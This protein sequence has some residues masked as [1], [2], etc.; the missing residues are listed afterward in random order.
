[1]LNLI[2]INVQYLP[3]AVFSFEKGSNGQKCSSSSPNH[4]IPLL[5]SP[6]FPISP[7]F[8]SPLLFGKPSILSEPLLRI[9]IKM[10][11]VLHK[12]FF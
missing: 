1:M 4:A 6:K 7:I 11:D 12:V 9:L 5:R 8:D 3:K 2:L 10:I